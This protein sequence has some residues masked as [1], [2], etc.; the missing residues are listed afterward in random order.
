MENLGPGFL[1]TTITGSFFTICMLRSYNHLR[2]SDLGL[3]GVYVC[4]CKHT[5]RKPYLPYVPTSPR[6]QRGRGLFACG[7]FGS[8]KRLG[9][10]AAEE[11][12]VEWPSL[13][14]PSFFSAHPLSTYHFLQGEVFQTMGRKKRIHFRGVLKGCFRVE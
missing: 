13:T 6:D 2:D 4:V 8:R 5:A 11:A 14:L 1:S 10:Q 3:A 9:S 7:F 12:L